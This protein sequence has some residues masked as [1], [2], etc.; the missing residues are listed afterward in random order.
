MLSYATLSSHSVS[1]PSLC[2]LGPILIISFMTTM[3]VCCLFSLGAPS[4]GAIII[5]RRAIQSSLEDAVASPGKDL[6]SRPA[7]VLRPAP[8]VQS[9]LLERS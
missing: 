5:G 8:F 9:S 2:G 3:M 6:V 4:S 1:C 7:V